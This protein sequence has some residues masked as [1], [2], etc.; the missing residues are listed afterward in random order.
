MIEQLQKDTAEWEKDKA[1]QLDC[2]SKTKWHKPGV[3][4]FKFRILPG[5]S[6]FAEMKGVQEMEKVRLTFHKLA[7]HVAATIRKRN[8]KDISGIKLK[9]KE[10]GWRREYV[11]DVNVFLRKGIYVAMQAHSDED[12]GIRIWAPYPQ[13]DE[14]LCDSQNKDKCQAAIQELQA[15]QD[16]EHL[17]PGKLYLKTLQA[18]LAT[19][20]PPSSTTTTSV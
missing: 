6:L 2:F 7:R 9:L 20:H 3:G 18:H 8:P 16:M 17:W 13:F 4:K 15:D 1:R 5:S 12:H 14:F 11:T 19:S 10:K